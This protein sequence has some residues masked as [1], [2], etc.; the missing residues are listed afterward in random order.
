MN[1]DSDQIPDAAIRSRGQLRERLAALVVP[2]VVIALGASAV[3]MTRYMEGVSD[4]VGRGETLGD[5][6][7]QDVVHL[8]GERGPADDDGHSITSGVVTLEASL[9]DIEATGT[10]VQNP[11]A[12]VALDTSSLGMDL[13]SISGAVQLMPV[14][15]VIG[16][17]ARMHEAV[18]DLRRAP[19]PL[20]DMPDSIGSWRPDTSPGSSGAPL[21]GLLVSP[22]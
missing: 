14:S 3:V 4:R 18:H 7:G 15:D 2:G 17:S 21:D 1:A 5:H 6:R 19:T 10:A 20:V 8:E 13:S 11:G 12:P 9:D 16:M 22:P